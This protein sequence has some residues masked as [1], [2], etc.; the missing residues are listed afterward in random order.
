[1]IAY[2]MMMAV[3]RRKVWSQISTKGSRVTKRQLFI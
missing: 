1:M 2:I 3:T